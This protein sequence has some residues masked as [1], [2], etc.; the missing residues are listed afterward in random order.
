[1]LLRTSISHMWGTSVVVGDEIYEIDA[2][3]VVTI[4]DVDHAAILMAGGCWVEVTKRA[5]IKATIDAPVEKVDI[6]PS[7]DDIDRAVE[8]VG[9]APPVEKKKVEKKKVEKK[10]LK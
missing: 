4:N 9:D 7:A 1:M 10:E 2:G 3:G 6:D 5:P 8:K